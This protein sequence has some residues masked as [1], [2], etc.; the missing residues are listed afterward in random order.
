MVKANRA[1]LMR[2]ASGHLI[3]SRVGSMSRDL[4]ASRRKLI[5]EGLQSLL[6]D[7]LKDLTV[8]LLLEMSSKR[9]LVD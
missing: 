6:A 9:S 3:E 7:L 2:D 5:D 8:I 1:G 4:T